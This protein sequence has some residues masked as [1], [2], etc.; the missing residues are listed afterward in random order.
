LATQVVD[1]RDILQSRR[2]TFEPKRRPRK[3]QVESET[4]QAARMTT[5][6]DAA[7]RR[8]VALRVP[9]VSI[10]GMLG[11]GTPSCSHSTQRKRMMYACATKK[12]TAIGMTGLPP[13]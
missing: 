13:L 3:N 11:M 7:L 5:S 12:S 4:A 6:E 8:L 10:S 2:R 1:S 9:A